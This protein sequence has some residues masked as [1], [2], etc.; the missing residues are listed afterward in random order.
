MN[1]YEHNADAGNGVVIESGTD[2]IT[3]D[4]SAIQVLVAAT[5]TVFTER[6][7]SG[8]AMTGFAV[9][10][11]TI[12]YNG[13]GITAFTMSSGTVRAYKCLTYSS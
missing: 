1:A 10:A 8:D 13:Q 12:L 2:A 7:S 4:F 6:G 9:P 11:G 5:F 3:G